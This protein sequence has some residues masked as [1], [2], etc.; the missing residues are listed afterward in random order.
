VYLKKMKLKHCLFLC[1][2]L[3]VILSMCVLLLVDFSLIIF[4]FISCFVFLAGGS[5]NLLEEVE[6]GDF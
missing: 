6:F 2:R 1:E 4:Y 3:T 5:L